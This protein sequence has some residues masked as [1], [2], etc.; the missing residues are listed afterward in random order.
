MPRCSGAP[1]PDLA[2]ARKLIDPARQCVGR[3]RVRLQASPA[4]LGSVGAPGTLHLRHQRL[5]HLWHLG[6]LGT[7]TRGRSSYATRLILSRCFGEMLSDVMLPPKPPQPSVI[8]G[9]S[10]VV[11]PIDPC[12]VGRVHANAIGRLVQAELENDG[13]VLRV[14]RHGVAHAAVAE[15]L[16]AALAAFAPVL[17]DVI[18]ED[19]AELLDRQRVVAADA[20]QLGDERARARRAP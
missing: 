14:D 3:N 8:A 9:S 13:V 6:T 12:V 5:R 4:T 20:F 15:D 7:W 11:R 16:L 1:V 2:V 19:G 17:D 18:G 10:P